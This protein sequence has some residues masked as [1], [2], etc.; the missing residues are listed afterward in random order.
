MVEINGTEMTITTEDEICF[1]KWGLGGW[2][3]EYTK[4]IMKKEDERL[5]AV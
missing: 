3:L 5:V 2:S 1:Y 4:I